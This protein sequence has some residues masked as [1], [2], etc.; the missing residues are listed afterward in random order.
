MID[1]THII[2][3]IIDHIRRVGGGYSDWYIGIADNLRRTLFDEHNVDKNLYTYFTKVAPNN[4][5]AEMIEKYFK[6]QGCQG[7]SETGNELS[8]VIYAY[9]ITNS[10][11]Q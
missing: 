9:R 3:E 7:D 5:A 10:T 6:D 11:I 2:N 8:R 1:N 4:M